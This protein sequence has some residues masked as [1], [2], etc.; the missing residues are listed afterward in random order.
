MAKNILIGDDNSQFRSTLRNFL[1]TQDE[2][3]V[4][5]EASS[6]KETIKKARE[7][8]PDLVVIDLAMSEMNGIQAARELRRMSPSTPLILFT[9]VESSRLADIAIA[10]GVNAVVSKSNPTEL[11][12][13]MY[14]L[15][16][17]TDAAL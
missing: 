15:L 4:V 11:L 13:Q 5:G 16:A 14:S 8:K 12:D 2:F 10:N 3:T 9:N 1:E 7:L 6:G 17:P